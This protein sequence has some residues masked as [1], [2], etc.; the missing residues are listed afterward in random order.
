[1]L[2]QNSKTKD[3]FSLVIGWP[4]NCTL[5]AMYTYMYNV[6]YMYNMCVHMRMHCAVCVWD[7]T[8]ARGL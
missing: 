8:K 4:S 2:I 3:V 5:C 1:M 7:Q 6:L